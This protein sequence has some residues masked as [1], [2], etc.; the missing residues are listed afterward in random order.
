M[1]SRT[2]FTNAA[3]SSLPK[4]RAISTASFSVTESGISSRQSSS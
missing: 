4:R 2:P 1:W 3:D